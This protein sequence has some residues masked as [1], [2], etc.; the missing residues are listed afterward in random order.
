MPRLRLPSACFISV[1]LQNVRLS[2]AGKPVLRGIDW[3]I[4]PGQRWV[5]MG[6]NGAGKTQL[7]K[8]LAGDVWP[9]PA[10]AHARR[11]HYRGE[12]FEDPYG[13]KQEI[14]YVG[15]ERQDRYEHYDWNLRVEAIVG[16]GLHS[17]SRCWVNTPLDPLGLSLD[18]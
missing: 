4:R 16:T 2:L 14:A 7:L 17:S 8:L 9:S 11:Y 15:A 5:L 12:T 10:S 13:L 18:V 1:D 3:K 6:P